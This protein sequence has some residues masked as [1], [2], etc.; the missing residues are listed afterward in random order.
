MF[1]R[2]WLMWVIWRDPQWGHFR[3]Q[4]EG[5]GYRVEMEW[6]GGRVW[7]SH[8]ERQVLPRLFPPPA[9]IT[10]RNKEGEAAFYRGVLIVCHVIV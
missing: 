5:S 10:L 7:R 3:V 6:L 9:K 2:L 4:S 1:G 8:M